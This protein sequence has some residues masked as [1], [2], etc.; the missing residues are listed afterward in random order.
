MAKANKKDIW[1]VI[2]ISIILIYILFL[3]Y[4]L[5]QLLKQA[6]VV[7]GQFS[8]EY[9]VK[10]FSKN[11]Y[12]TT[13]KNSFEVSIAATII[14]LIIGIPLA[15]FYQMYEIKGKTILQILII[16][17]SMSAPFIG[18]YSWILLLGRNGLITA[19]IKNLTGIQLPSIYGFNGILL[20]LSLQYSH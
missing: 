10:F 12:L 8:L 11:Y 6:V 13:I 19:G 17:C 15:Y 2:S 9:F 7:D 20:V 14:T 18:A 16:L 1:K 5:F 4:P 3:I